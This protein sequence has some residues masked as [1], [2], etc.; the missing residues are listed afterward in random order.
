M[1]H[2][3]IIIIAALVATVFLAVFLTR[4]R[5]IVLFTVTALLLCE[6]IL[7]L[8]SQNLLQ[9]YF[10]PDKPISTEASSDDYDLLSYR[11][12]LSGDF[13][14][15]EDVLKER[16]ETAGYSDEYL[17]ACAR[18]YL[19]KKDGKAAYCLYE[20][21]DE[22]KSQAEDDPV[23]SEKKAAVEY[24][25]DGDWKSASEI[26]EENIR[27]G[28]GDN[29]DDIF[30]E[31]VALI[32]RMS[33]G[34]NKGDGVS[35]LTQMKT[36]DLQLKID[37]I[38]KERPALSDISAVRNMML[39]HYL[40]SN[41]YKAIIELIDEKSSGSDFLIIAELYRH[42][43]I[44][45]EDFLKEE[46][47]ESSVT[48]AKRNKE[49]IEKQLDRYNYSDA[50]KKLLRSYLQELELITEEPAEA[51]VMWLKTVLQ[52]KAEDVNEKERTKLL[53]QLSRIAYEEGDEEKS[54]K[55]LR[56]TLDTGS[57]S[58]DYSFVGPV[59][60]IK[61]LL[62]EDEDKEELKKVEEYVD[63]MVDNMQPEILKSA[64]IGQTADV[65]AFARE[66]TNE[67]VT[68]G[69]ETDAEPEK[70]TVQYSAQENKSY[71]AFVSGQVNQM[72]ATVSISS[73]NSKNF[74]KITTVVS[75]D[76]SVA[77]TEESFRNNF[78]LFD[79]DIEIDNYEI[80]KLANE[81]I[82]IVLCCDNSG[83]MEGES[84]DNL[85]SALKGFVSTV[86]KGANIGIVVFR[87]NVDSNYIASIGSGPVSLNKMIEDMTAHGGTNI[88]S[89]IQ[90]SIDMFVN[91]KGINAIFLLSDGQDSPPDADRM[92]ELS[93]ACADLGLQIY[94]MGLGPD[95]DANVLSEYATNTGGR[96][97][98]VSNSGELSSF[99]DYLYQFSQNRYEITYDALD[100]IT[101]SREL[102]V[103]YRQD[104]NVY[105]T[106]KYSLYEDIDLLSEDDSGLKDSK[107]SDY[108]VTLQ[109]AVVGGL[110]T[111]LLYKSSVD[112]EIFL[113]GKNLK[114]EYDVK[115]SIHAGVDYDLDATY[116][117]DTRWKV[118]VPARAACGNYDVY[119]TVNK[120][121]AVFSSGLVIADDT[122]HVVSFGDYVFTSTGISVLDKT[123]ELSG[124]TRMNDWMGFTGVVTI[125]GD[126]KKDR[127][128]TVSWDKSYIQYK[129][130]DSPQGFAGYLA[131][132][133]YSLSLPAAT[134]LTLYRNDM[135]RPSSED[136]KVDHYTAS[137]YG[138]IDLFSMPSC[139]FVL[140]P[141]RAEVNVLSVSLEFPFLDFLMK[142][143][144][145]RGS[146]KRDSLL[147][148]D[149][150]T[151]FKMV[152]DDQK[153]GMDFSFKYSRKDNTLHPIKLGNYAI[154]LGADNVELGVNTYT[155]DIYLEYVTK[156]FP[157]SDT[158]G[159]RLEWKEFKFDT[160]LIK[161]DHD[162]TFYPGGVPLTVSDF[163][164]GL[165]NISEGAEDGFW[166]A[167][168]HMVLRGGC[169]LSVVKV[170]G[171][172]PGLEAWVGDASFLGFDDIKMELN[173]AKATLEA[174]G[175][176]QFLEIDVGSLSFKVG[177]RLSY[178]NMLLDMDEE[179]MFGVIA[180]A[181]I[182]LGF[183]LHKSEAR[184]KGEYEPVITNKVMTLVNL[185]GEL[186]LKF[187]LWVITNDI[188]SQGDFFLG[189]YRQ[190]NGDYVF[191]VLAGS[192]GKRSLCALWGQNTSLGS[193]V[194]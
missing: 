155:G 166:E 77:N 133:G 101:T 107:V 44:T 172:L 184:I 102:K 54:R 127:E 76:D 72:S 117:D 121:R 104:R 70:K 14:T 124:Y 36:D 4:K 131:D 67:L 177:Y 193:V 174:E 139:D 118:V 5:H 128:I 49:W 83:S 68:N 88:Y 138:L 150:D 146:T 24:L 79:C 111:K 140:Y 119:V 191:G 185:R 87:D 110:E 28:I 103:E 6:L 27:N 96:Y 178:T 53:L 81:Q 43:K 123:I 130:Q 80:K 86:A 157:S 89:G 165:T 95:V 115:V 164:A 19:L 3:I 50:D 116:V 91:K 16:Q 129:K 136:Y 7:L 65:S 148:F 168:K 17:L 182:D 156:L 12:M 147:D 58:T 26:V 34:E 98:Y 94:A 100:T 158:G 171:V 160:V 189:I 73:L 42:N 57:E 190:H 145:A 162:V 25:E 175:K 194:M 59:G 176:F 112:Q 142:G 10:F 75:V 170:S 45:K 92:Y 23:R 1:E 61:K 29:S 192:N 60:K 181:A 144:K 106:R 40:L 82:N 135:A 35:E 151:E 63:M 31:C 37:R 163:N 66:V 122:M 93:E 39:K 137:N 48:K 56:K 99:Y 21:L 132:K 169:D 78:R 85:K 69:S 153:V 180:N 30:S 62:S 152:V 97:T 41:N 90:R 161:Y 188:K 113:L 120:K 15:A 167:V 71:A 46:Y 126:V 9:E 2:I 134:G 64:G 114:K 8:K 52:E 183:K 143:A 186:E 109:D 33:D 105:A 51:Y 13:Q 149:F 32:D 38:N 55:Y 18:L 125:D 159:F 84:I 22:D 187:R 74:S 20:Q 173:I 154:K 179:E 141:D 108:Q 11:L 47:L